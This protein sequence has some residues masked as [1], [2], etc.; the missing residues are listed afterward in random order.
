M[1][2]FFSDSHFEKHCGAQLYRQLPD[3]LRSRMVFTENEWDILE[4]GDWEKDC[5][6]L[7]LNMIGTTCA[8]P[9]PGS[10]AE[11]AVKRYIERGG[12]VLM[13]HGSSA[14]FWQW[15]WWREIVGLRWVR[16]NDPDGVEA[17]THPVKPCLLRPCKVRHPLAAGMQSIQLPQDE[18]YINLEQVSPVTVLMDVCIE[19]GVFPQCFENLTPWGG[20]F[21][22]FIPGHS[23]EVTTNPEIIKVISCLAEYLLKEV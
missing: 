8:Q 10:G 5:E 2:Y 11:A 17:S 4:K 21:C 6:L 9:H 19:E 16:P 20:R 22:H 18:I 23:P 12:N 1:I 3:A 15:P 14:A 13:L 7:I